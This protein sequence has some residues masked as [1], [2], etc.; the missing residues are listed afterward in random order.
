MSPR[1]PPRPRA[2]TAP[3]LEAETA[4]APASPP[5]SPAQP[6]DFLQHYKLAWDRCLKAWPLF[7]VQVGFQ[8]LTM[9]FFV[10]LLLLFFGPM[11]GRL[12]KDYPALD[13]KNIPSSY[14]GQLFTH[15]YL[16]YMIVLGA[17]AFLWLIIL[18]MLVQ[19]GMLGR[20][21]NYACGGTGFSLKE[22]F[23]DMSRLFAPLVGYQF[24][25]LAAALIP[26]GLVVLAGVALY[27]LFKDSGGAGVAAAVLLV[28]A[29][30][31]VFM[32]VAALAGA[33]LQIGLG[34]LSAGRGIMESFRLGWSSMKANGWRWL[35]LF[36]LYM[37]AIM[38]VMM[39]VGMVLGI[40]ELIPVLGIL[41]AIIRM[42]FQTAFGIFIAV[43]QPVLTITYLHENNLEQPRRE[44]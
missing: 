44:G 19:A 40:L 8:I 23:K 24:V 4:E 36:L 5:P 2:K 17:L 35:W 34:H 9:G 37:V 32:L 11:I 38:G 10:V 41:F 30:L 33:Y 29:A 1:L 15:D 31:C 21:W 13:F 18:G 16:V 26:L 7:L 39:A 42:I 14:W 3:V 12:F 43:Y 20:L 22:F 6:P 28:I 25:V 27:P